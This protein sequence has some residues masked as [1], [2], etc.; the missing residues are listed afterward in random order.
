MTT[1]EVSRTTK[2]ILIAEFVLL[3]YMLYVLSTSLYKSYQVDNFIK[4]AEED[5]A[6]LE[7]SNSLLIED[8]EYYKSDSY[9]EKIAKQN[10]GLVRPGEEV[11]ILAKSTNQTP[12]LSNEDRAD[13]L[14][15]GYYD[16]LNNPQK[17][18]FFFFDRERFAM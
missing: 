4:R 11:I 6:K 5:N 10:F 9:K 12:A 17:W 1:P 15:K 14:S 2:M 18:F 8:Y 13:L 16:K 3:S 7:K